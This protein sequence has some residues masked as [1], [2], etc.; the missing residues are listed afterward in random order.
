ME[1]TNP[2]FGMRLPRALGV[3]HM[4]DA[5]DDIRMGTHIPEVF[6]S[7]NTGVVANYVRKYTRE[8]QESE[9]ASE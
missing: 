7:R 6:R 5:A 2:G 1:V 4:D 3:T 8:R 9:E